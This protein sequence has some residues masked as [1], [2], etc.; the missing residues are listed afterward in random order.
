MVDHEVEN[1][2]CKLKNEYS[3]FKMKRKNAENRLKANMLIKVALEEL[4]A[5]QESLLKTNANFEDYC[6]KIR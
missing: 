2:I 6:N 4:V 3:V 5:N 1:E